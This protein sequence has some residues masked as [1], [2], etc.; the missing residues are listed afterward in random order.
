MRSVRENYPE[1]HKNHEEEQYLYRYSPHF[2]YNQEL[3]CQND[4]VQINIALPSQNA[5]S[6]PASHY[7]E[8]SVK[9]SELQ[10]IVLCITTINRLG[11]TM[12]MYSCIDKKNILNV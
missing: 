12:V 11:R 6:I 10:V 9:G 4:I 3:R 2:L 5:V 7:P 1:E 8:L